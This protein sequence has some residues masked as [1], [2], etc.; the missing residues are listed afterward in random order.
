MFLLY[1]SLKYLFQKVAEKNK[2]MMKYFWNLCFGLVGGDL[3]CKPPEKKSPA[4]F[5][6]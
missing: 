4:Y 6:T 1:I 2:S 5:I 3:F